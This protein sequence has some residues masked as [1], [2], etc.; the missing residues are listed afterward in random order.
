MLASRGAHGAGC[1]EQLGSGKNSFVCGMCAKELVCVWLVRDGVLLL[2]FFSTL[3][4]LWDFH[5][6]V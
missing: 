5:V 4:A 6:G 1:G 3:D 2:I